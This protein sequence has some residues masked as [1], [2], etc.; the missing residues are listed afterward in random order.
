MMTDKGKTRSG[1]EDGF[2]QEPSKSD[3]GGVDAS[4][5]SARDEQSLPEDSSILV[6][7]VPDGTTPQ[8]GPDS[9]WKRVPLVMPLSAVL[10]TGLMLTMAG[11]IATEFQPQDKAEALAFEINPIERIIETPPDIQEPEILKKIETPPPPPKLA[12]H[13]VDAVVEPGYKVTKIKPILSLPPLDLGKTTISAPDTNE[14][15]LVR[16]PPVMPA[17]FLQ[18]DES[19]FCNM[20]FSISP[21]G[22]PYDV[23][24]TQC[25]HSVLERASIKSVLRWKY[26]PKVQDGR[27]VAR[28][29]IETKIRF[30]LA[31]GRGQRLPLPSGFAG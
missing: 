22:Q 31:D 9:P 7:T 28:S 26:N 23:A 24:A 11:L 15:P 14:Q 4:R 25:T 8:P 2:R 30:D 16:I 5:G 20:R 27:A 10:T 21:D 13:N 12:T 18:G 17:R 29:G 3:A 6:A 1:R 19:G